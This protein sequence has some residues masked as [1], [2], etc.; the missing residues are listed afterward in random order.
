MIGK[1]TGALLLAMVLVAGSMAACG[2]SEGS[3]AGNAAQGN[4]E[5]ADTSA[6]AGESTADGSTEAASDSNASGGDAAA[7][8]TYNVTWDDMEDIIVVYPSMGAI[9]TGL[10][11][12]EDAINEITEAEINTHVT[13]NMIEV[14]NYDQQMNL[15]ISSSEPVD[16]MITLPGG[17]TALSAMT[18]QKQL[19]DITDLLSEYAPEAL[20]GVGDVIKGTQLDG[21]TYAFPAYR[22]FS[23]AIYI[24]MRTD[25]LEETGIDPSTLKT[26]DDFEELF[27][28]VT[29][30]HPE[31]TPVATGSQ[32]ILT[33]PYLIDTEGNFVKYDGLGDGDNSLVGIM[34][35]DGTTIQNNYTRQVYI[36]TSLRFK[37]WYDNGW[38]Y[39]DGANYKE[40]Q[41]ALIAGGAC[42]GLFKCFATGAE[43]TE[44]A[45]C[46]YDMTIIQID[47]SPEINTGMLRKFSWAVP[48]TATEPEAAVK[49]MNL[50]FTDEEIV[51]LITWGIEGT[52]YQVLEDGTIDFMDGQDANTSGYYI[53]DETAI[54]GNGFLAKVWTGNSPTLR[55]DT[56]EVNMN[57]TVSPYTGF[58]FNSEGFENQVAAITQ[59][60]QQYRPSFGCGLY[61]EDYYNEF[62]SKLEDNGVNEYIAYIQEQFNAW[63]AENGN[64]AASDT[65]ADAAETTA[66]SEAADAG[67]ESAA[68]TEAAE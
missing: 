10:Q 2:N 47:P 30:L 20:A 48:V 50:L 60:I 59:T 42:F 24:N 15:M 32:K 1:K 16:L 37:E 6:G 13:L 5:A 49:F 43:S 56:Y 67:A 11:E 34:E 39:A 57:A 22:S 62:I 28:K 45:S 66:D 52:H 55:E 19:M 27:A 7:S 63:L 35:G 3:D 46:G 40:T 61:T 21:G 64:A 14:G 12:V 29:E 31:M 68:E 44:S 23:S 9:P 36:D 33:A 25:V 26:A 54:L 8:G 41:E 4:T 38:V 17:T 58:S 18:S 53:G 51:N 65:G